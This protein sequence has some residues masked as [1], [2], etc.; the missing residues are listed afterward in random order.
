MVMLEDDF[1]TSASDIDEQSVPSKISSVGDK[2][3]GD[4]VDNSGPLEQTGYRALEFPDPELFLNFYDEH[5]N[6]GRVTLHPWQSEELEKIGVTKATAQHPYKFCLVTCNGS[7]KD[8]FIIAP[9]VVW[10]AASKIRSRCIITSSSGV[11][12]TSQTEGYIKT[13]CQKVNEK[14]SCEIFRIRQRYIKCMLSGSE[15]RMF[16]TDEAGK[17]EGYHP[18]DPDSEMMIVVNE[19]KSVSEEIHGA[20]RRCTGYNYWLEISSPG[21]PIGYFYKAATSWH[22]V[23]YVDY[24]LCPHR[25]VEEIEEDKIELGETSALYRSKNL[26]M[27]T[28]TS[29]ETVIPQDLVESIL[30]DASNGT[31]KNNSFID[32]KVRV[33][34]DL[35]AGGDENVICFVLGNKCIKEVYFRET[36]TEI[37]ADKIAEILKDNKIPKDYKYITADDGGVGHSIIDKLRK[38]GWNITRMMNQW[39]ASNK[40]LYGNKGAELWYRAKRII[41]ERLFDLSSL[42]E[43]TRQQ[44]YTRHFKKV[45]TSSRLF[46][47]AKKEAKAK[48]R[49]S[50]DRADAFILA[51]SGLNVD[52]YLKHQ[53]DSSEPKDNRPKDRFTSVEELQE[54]FE[55]KVTFANF[56]EKQDK[57]PK[58]KRIF[59]SLRAILIGD[60]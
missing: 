34:I 35:A 12:L 46:L 38:R 36:D 57:Q 13:L 54:H 41:E 53:S 5:I 42:S 25:S 16:A 55:D 6:S 3:D 30:K 31:Y 45:S 39:A 51:L 58:K 40:K 56:N 9:T 2:Y 4:F 11:Q 22:N 18:M 52:D 49:P 44:L 26:A 24:T 27:F 32:F 10:F 37:S 29:D 33:G 47:E 19:G 28:S 23:R 60:N 50:P 21:E 15:I 8:A 14:H 20:L 7:G 43:K 48:G 1:N 59:N 17:A